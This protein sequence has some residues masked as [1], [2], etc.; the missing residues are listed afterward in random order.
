MRK[1]AEKRREKRKEEERRGE[2][3]KEQEGRE[4]SHTESH[5]LDVGMADLFAAGPLGEGVVNFST[6]G[7]GGVVTPATPTPPPF[8]EAPISPRI[9]S[10]PAGVIARGDERPPLPPPPPPLPGPRCVAGDCSRGPGVLPRR[11][12]SFNS[13]TCKEAD[14][15]S[16][17]APGYKSSREE[18]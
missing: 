10:L 5:L 8:R 12:L 7:G 17:T 1:E 3:S 2:E 4:K 6:G 11:V 13:T 15:S 14:F 9:T 16:I 18:G